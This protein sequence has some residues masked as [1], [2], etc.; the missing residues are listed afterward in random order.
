MYVREILKKR[1]HAIS[2]EFFPP[3]TLDEEAA[4]FKNLEKLR[5]WD[6]AF[7]SVTYGAGGSTHEKSLELT[8]K[9]KDMGLEVVAH[10][11]C[12]GANREKI[13]EI[14]SYLKT[15]GIE[16]IL[17]LRGDPPQ[18]ERE[19]KP[20]P[21]GFRYAYQLVDFIKRNNSFCIGVAGYPEGHIENPDKEK[22]LQ[23]LKLKVDTGADFVITQLFF[24]NQLFLNFIERARNI[25]INVPIIPGI[26]P[27]TNL[28]Q[29]VRFTQ[30]C[31]ASIPAELLARLKRGGS[32]EVKRVGVEH[33]YQQCKGLLERGI[34][35][36]HFYTLNR[37]RA[38]AEIL[39]RLFGKR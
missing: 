22:D 37:S 18:G 34:K 17:A 35:T 6:P 13:L 4:L 23:Y 33:A 14:I 5:Q 39:T 11:T 26:M 19:F 3:K 10:L 15:Y 1:E 27:V 12:V 8:R 2:Y 9:M 28:N 20:V 25:G 30:L 29:I 7:V 16:N 31:G 32:E 21:G 38:T 24:E 36:L